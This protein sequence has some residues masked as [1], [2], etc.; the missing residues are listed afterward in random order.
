MGLIMGSQK[1]MGSDYG[2]NISVSLLNIGGSYSKLALP[3]LEH[4]V[5]IFQ[6]LVKNKHLDFVCLWL[7][8]K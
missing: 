2:S 8:T 5:S 6:I 7:G 3:G 4:N 1:I